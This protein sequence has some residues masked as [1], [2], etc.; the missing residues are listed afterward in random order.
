MSVVLILSVT[1]IVVVSIIS[2]SCVKYYS[3]EAKRAL[4]NATDKYTNLDTLMRF[5]D[6]E[7]ERILRNKEAEC[8]RMSD[9]I[10]S[11]MEKQSRLS[12]DANI[13]KG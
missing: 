10:K 9:I 7:H 8:L 3:S 6:S 13:S 4:V 1:L 5:K 11:L 2:F 12:V